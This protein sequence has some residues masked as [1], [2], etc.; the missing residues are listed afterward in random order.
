MT[1]P[2][3]LCYRATIKAGY[4]G[5]KSVNRLSFTAAIALLAATPIAAQQLTPPSF[6]FIQAVE[7]SDGDKATQLLT[8]NPRIVNSRDEKGDTALIVAISREDADWT[9]FLLKKGADVNLGG[10]D[11]D[12]PLI[13]A[14]R[15]GF[16]DAI[17][18]LISLG[19]K[20]DAPNRSGET[21]LIVAVQQRQ[22]QIVSVLLDHGANPDRSDTIAGFSARD[23]AARD[24]RGRQILQLIEAKKPKPA[25][26]R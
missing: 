12:T 21:P 19:A 20:V 2:P 9:G 8:D 25:A 26:A 4:V 15:V 18:W 1:T 23:Y 16:E 14:A 5:S 10:R 7:K 17:E 11:G 13:A 22:P 24:N 3:L 6:E